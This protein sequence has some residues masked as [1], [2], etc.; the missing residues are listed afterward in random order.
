MS[1]YVDSH[2]EGA[3]VAIARSVLLSHV[4][5]HGPEFRRV[6]IHYTDAMPVT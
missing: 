4:Y 1:A 6:G 3:A 2:D 5:E